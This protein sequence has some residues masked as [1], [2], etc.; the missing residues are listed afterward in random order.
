MDRIVVNKVAAEPLITQAYLTS[1]AH[2]KKMAEQ[3]ASS[4]IV[5]FTLPS[6]SDGNKVLEKLE[7]HGLKC[8]ERGFG[9]TRNHDGTY[10][11]RISISVVE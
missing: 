5:N 6:Y 7:K 3:G 1:L 4:Y 10:D 9:N 2:I 11:F 8:N